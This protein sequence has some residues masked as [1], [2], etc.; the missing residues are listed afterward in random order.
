MS[1]DGLPLT[2]LDGDILMRAVA[3]ELLATI[4]PTSSKHATARAIAHTAALRTFRPGIYR[5]E[6]QEDA[7]HHARRDLLAQAVP[8]AD[9]ASLAD[10]LRRLLPEIY[11]RRPGALAD[12]YAL[13]C[14]IGRLEAGADALAADA[15][16]TDAHRASAI[17]AGQVATFPR[18][19]SRL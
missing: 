15:Q 7:E 12:A 2:N 11:Q 13:A 19:P 4:L 8:S 16:A 5:Y 1:I 6:W 14:Q 10:Q 18:R 3:D 9:T 17:G